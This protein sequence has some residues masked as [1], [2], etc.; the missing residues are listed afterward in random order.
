MDPKRTYDYFFMFLYIELDEHSHNLV[1]FK[2]D[3]DATRMRPLSQLF[4]TGF[5]FQIELQNK[6][7]CMFYRKSQ[8]SNPYKEKRYSGG[9]KQICSVIQD[10]E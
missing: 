6:V 9:D 8:Q 5:V 4:S 10:F 7:F 2:T 3:G 1:R